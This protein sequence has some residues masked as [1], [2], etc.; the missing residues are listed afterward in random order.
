MEV[1]NHADTMVLGSSCLP[2][3][4]FGRSVDISG[5]ESSTGSVECP[6]ISGDIVYDHPTVKNVENLY[7]II[8]VISYG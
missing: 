4:D 7:A 3:H 8:V 1:D 6:T 2:I 5:W